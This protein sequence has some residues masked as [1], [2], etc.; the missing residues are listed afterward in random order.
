MRCQI[1][2]ILIASHDGTGIWHA[3]LFYNHFVCKQPTGEAY[4]YKYMYWLYYT[5]Y[6]C[7]RLWSCVLWK[8][9]LLLLLLLYTCFY[10]MWYSKGENSLATAKILN[11]FILNILCFTSIFVYCQFQINVCNFVPVLLCIFLFSSETY[12]NTLWPFIWEKDLF[13]SFTP[14][15]IFVGDLY[16]FWLTKA[17][18]KL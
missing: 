3:I 5:Y 4:L 12:N 11:L 1:P 18:L 7:T 10:T 13:C 14:K 8:T 16:M 6:L 2:E 9:A 15:P 17:N